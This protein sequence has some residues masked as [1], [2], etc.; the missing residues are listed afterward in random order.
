LRGALFCSLHSPSLPLSPC[1]YLWV[2]APAVRPTCPPTLACEYW[3]STR[4]SACLFP[5]AA[6]SPERETAPP[7]SSSFGCSFGSVAERELFA[8][9]A[10]VSG[11]RCKT[12]VARA[13]E[14][15]WITA[16]KGSF[17]LGGSNRGVREATR[18]D[19]HR[20]RRRSGGADAG[21]AGGAPTAETALPSRSS[22]DSWRPR[23][24]PAAAAHGF[25][26]GARVGRSEGGSRPPPICRMDQA[27]SSRARSTRCPQRPLSLS[28]SRRGAAFS[29]PAP[30]K[31]HTQ[32]WMKITIF[33]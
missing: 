3:A 32:P 11:V 5:S 18:A 26:S 30:Q 10:L 12:A 14:Q 9:N 28:R 27:P 17:T 33:F 31:T 2:C 7:A 4:A 19:T 23:L 20:E 22:S 29:R 25:L 13:A 1:L 15:E 24:P 21:R 8:T 6:R 16:R